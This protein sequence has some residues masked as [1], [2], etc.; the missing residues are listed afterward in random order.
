MGPGRLINV[1]TPSSGGEFVTISYLV[2]EQDADLAIKIIKS[3]IARSTDEVLAVSR[4]SEQLL[5]ALGVPPGGFTR[6]DG[7]SFQRQTTDNH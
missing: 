3:K 1:R 5:D 4:V 2:A 6:A 7:K